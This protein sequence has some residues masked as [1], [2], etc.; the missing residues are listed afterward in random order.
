MSAILEQS[1]KVLGI[2]EEVLSRIGQHLTEQCKGD[3][4]IVT[5]KLDEH[6]VAAY[7]YSWLASELLAARQMAR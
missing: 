7:D 2:V 3:G 5:A 1:D 4:K 6:Q